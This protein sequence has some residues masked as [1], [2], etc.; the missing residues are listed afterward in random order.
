MIER[1]VK[2]AFADADTAR[3]ALRTAG[4]APLRAR[5]LQR[6]T[7]YDTPDSRLRTAG[8]VLRLRDDGGQAFVTLKGPVQQGSMKVREEQES[9]VEDAGVLA[10]VFEALGLQPAFLYE[11]YRE[12]FTLAGTVVALDETPVGVYMEIEGAENAILA[13]TEALGRTPRD[14]NRDSYRAI[15]LASQTGTGAPVRDMVFPRA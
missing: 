2:L 1:E 10:A 4:A 14:F 11:K 8:R 13:A 12:E 15:F 7:I 9:A 3:A 5:R 6:D